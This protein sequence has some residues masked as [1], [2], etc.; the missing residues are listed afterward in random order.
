MYHSVWF[1]VCDVTPPQRWPSH[2]G[3][4]IYI[5]GVC[6]SDGSGILLQE[7]HAQCTTLQRHKFC[8]QHFCWQPHALYGTDTESHRLCTQQSHVLC[9]TLLQ[10]PF[11]LYTG[12]ELGGVGVGGGGEGITTTL[13]QRATSCALNTC[14]GRQMFST[15]KCVS[16]YAM[17][18]PSGSSEESK[19]TP[20]IL[21][22]PAMGCLET[23]YWSQVPTN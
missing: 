8:T 16:F 7:P 12:V 1:P 5:M 20:N 19:Y 13:L 22:H 9:K 6:M 21:S 11:A 23:G 2:P 10:E 3:V 14:T 18:N 4:L 17:V 15:Q